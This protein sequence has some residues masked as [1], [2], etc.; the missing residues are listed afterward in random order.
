MQRLSCFHRRTHTYNIAHSYQRLRIA[1]TAFL[2]QI[3]SILP[4]Y[5]RVWF[6]VSWMLTSLNWWKLHNLH[7]GRTAFLFYY[8]LFVVSQKKLW[9]W[10]RVWFGLGSKFNCSIS[11][12]SGSG[13]SLK[14]VQTSTLYPTVLKKIPLMNQVRGQFTKKRTMPVLFVYTYYLDCFLVKHPLH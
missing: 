1:Q 13:F 12:G 14:P 10:V 11:V 4:H 9:F 5:I 2:I 3:N 8:W 7:S 6:K